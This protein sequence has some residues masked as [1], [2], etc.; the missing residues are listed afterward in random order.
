MRY[1][2]KMNKK[3]LIEVSAR[4]IH[5]SRG[6]LEPLFGKSY[7]LKKLRILP[8]TKQFAAKETL[9][10]QAGSKK[11]P[12]VRIVGPLRKKT[13]IELSITD[14]IK[15]GINPPIRLS[16]NLKGTPG[17]TLISPK[18]KIKL[19]SGVIIAQRH[20]HCN[21]KEAKELGF[22]DGDLVPVEVKGKR[23]LIFHNVK[24]RVNKNWRLCLHLDTDEGNAAG[25]IKKGEGI[26][27]K[28]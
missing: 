1:N 24:V 7:Q 2:I 26:I 10:I 21:S 3:I 15:L 14:A 22:K 16:G 6:D 5:L 17:I 19:K 27:L 11:I 28:N 23:A 13:Q 4:H 25:I 9:G 20:I 8:T 12:N 18:R